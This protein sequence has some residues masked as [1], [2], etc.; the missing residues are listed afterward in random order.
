MPPGRV[1]AN[2]CCAGGGRCQVLYRPYKQIINVEV[3]A[4]IDHLLFSNSV[5]GPS[6]QKLQALLKPSGA[7]A[8]RT[9]SSTV[10]GTLCRLCSTDFLCPQGF[11]A[12]SVRTGSPEAARRPCMG[13]LII[14][15]RL[16]QT[17][18]RKGRVQ[19]EGWAEGK[20]WCRQGKSGAIKSVFGDNFGFA[21]GS[22]IR[23][24]V[25]PANLEKMC[26]FISRNVDTNVGRALD[27]ES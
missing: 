6:G 25:L 16:R 12:V 9:E 2:R 10:F 22:L 15:R 27:I 7:C 24:I 3:F 14:R 21:A 18:L 19:K 13:C 1:S 17:V 8:H 11:R 26:R 4:K 23:Q 20:P 5:R